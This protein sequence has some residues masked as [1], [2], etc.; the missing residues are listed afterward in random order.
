MIAA[1]NKGQEKQLCI[2]SWKGVKHN[3]VI[4]SK[5]LYG[6]ADLVPEKR[7]SPSGFHGT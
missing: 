4:W 3:P 2:A 6:V 1:Y 5:A 7:R